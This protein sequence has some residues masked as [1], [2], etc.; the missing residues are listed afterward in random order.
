MNSINREELLQRFV[1]GLPD[2]V[3][4]LDVGGTVLTW[5][6]GARDITG[7]EADEIVG[8]N[9]S[10]LYTPHDL[11]ADKPAVSL[12]GARAQGCLEETGQRVRKDG[13]ALEV[14]NVLMPI[15]DSSKQLV[16]FGS[17]M[18]ARKASMPAAPSVAGAGVPA[19]P[20]E[21][22]LVVDDDAAVR[23]GVSHQLTSLG[24]RAV[25]ASNGLEAL[26]MMAREP[27]IDLLFTDVIMPGGMNG[28]EVAEEARLM[29]PSLK[30]LF[31]SGYF[32]DALLRNGTIDGSIR[33]LAKPYRKAELARTVQEA[34]RSTAA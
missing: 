9:F 32:E 25:V 12:E 10:C 18:R 19:R 1:A 8:R 17:R 22:I 26:D 30:V 2:A 28:R 5:N 16:G 31:T 21:T 34:L 29:D 13:T 4:V 3:V 20:C 33:L 15:Y 11:A 27:R 6:A 24:Y 23:E 7:Y 14:Q